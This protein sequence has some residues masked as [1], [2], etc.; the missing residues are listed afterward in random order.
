MSVT[1]SIGEKSLVDYTTKLIEGV[2][3]P[4]PHKF[5]TFLKSFIDE[6]IEDYSKQQ[7]HSICAKFNLDTQKDKTIRIPKYV[8]KQYVNPKKIKNKWQYS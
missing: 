6:N 4:T 5:D 2:D 8:E 1:S 7:I 3:P